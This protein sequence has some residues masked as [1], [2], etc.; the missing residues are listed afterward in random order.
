MRRP[1][2]CD[3]RYT[4]HATTRD[5]AKAAHLLKLPGAAE[6]LKIF[7]GCDLLK[8][9]SFGN[10]MDGCDAVFH[11]ASPFY[12]QTGS[13]EAL[14]KPA[15]DG[16]RNVLLACVAHGVSKVILTASTANVYVTYGANERLAFP[17][18]PA[19]VTVCQ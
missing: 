16:T 11:T 19:R 4:V 2:W 9:G 17:Q 5:E 1:Q 14:V 18:A 7:P 13:E 6:R 8:I 3:D 10:A 15:V 12:T